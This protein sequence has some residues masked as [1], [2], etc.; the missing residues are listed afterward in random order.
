MRA[1]SFVPDIL[2]G[3]IFA[4]KEEQPVPRTLQSNPSRMTYFWKVANFWI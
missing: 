1:T 3:V 2:L 4:E